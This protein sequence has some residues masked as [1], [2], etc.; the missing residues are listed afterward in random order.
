MSSDEALL[1]PK[2]KGGGV[3]FSD[4]DEIPLT[5]VEEED[6]DAGSD[7]SARAKPIAFGEKTTE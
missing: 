1:A 5:T 2:T 6:D 7:S 4:K 3:E